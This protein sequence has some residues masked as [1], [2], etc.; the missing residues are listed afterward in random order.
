MPNSQKDWFPT[1]IWH[2]IL[3]DYQQLNDTLLQEIRA[4]QQLDPKGEK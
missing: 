1:P 4:E 3:D 2:F